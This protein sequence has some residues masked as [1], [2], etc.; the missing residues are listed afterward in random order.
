MESIPQ[1][2]LV[3][4]LPGKELQDRLESFLEPVFVQL[5]EKRLRDVAQ[6]AVQAI[7]AAQSPVLTE[8]APRRPSGRTP[9]DCTAL[10]GISVSVIASC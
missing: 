6:V 10:S 4:K 1:N 5:P 9:S 8:V 7:V 2:A 3:D